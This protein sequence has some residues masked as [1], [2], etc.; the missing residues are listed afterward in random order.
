MTGRTVE[1]AFSISMLI[2]ISI[3]IHS[4][5][6]AILFVSLGCE[7]ACLHVEYA[8]SFQQHARRFWFTKSP[9]C[10]PHK[11]ARIVS[12]IREHR[13]QL[14]VAILLLVHLLI[15]PG[16]MHVPSPRPLH[17]LLLQQRRARHYSPVMVGTAVL[18][19]NNAND[20][21]NTNYKYCS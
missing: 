18:C 9:R 17:C 1:T 12:A 13:G 15:L 3:S 8:V 21:A 16:V 4:A 10:L 6:F 5:K 14:I 20:N 2:S 7:C 11:Y 19:H